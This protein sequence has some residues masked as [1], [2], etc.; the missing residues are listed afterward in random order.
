[1]NGDIVADEVDERI[2]YLISKV[3]VVSRLHINEERFL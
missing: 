2:K 3:L 1:M